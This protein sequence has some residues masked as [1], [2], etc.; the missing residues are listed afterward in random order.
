MPAAANEAWRTA[1]PIM[2]AHAIVTSIVLFFTLAVPRMAFDVLAMTGLFPLMPTALLGTAASNFAL[3][4]RAGQ[5]DYA[6][7]FA[8]LH[9]VLGTT[10]PITLFALTLLASRVP[11]MANP[12]PAVAIVLP[13]IVAAFIWFAHL[14]GALPDLGTRGRDF[15]D[16]PP[17]LSF[18]VAFT[19]WAWPFMA[20]VSGLTALQLF[21][22]WRKSAGR[23]EP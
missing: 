15:L 18:S 6:A 19:A 13:L 23:S 10:A 4:E 5:A 12:N 16:R 2:I 22:T 8:V 20:L 17:W 11:P 9:A 1:R 14:D 7:G 21:R 3:L